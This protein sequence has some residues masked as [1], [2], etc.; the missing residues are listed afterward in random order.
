[1]G[2][3]WVEPHPYPLQ[4]LCVNSFWKRDCTEEK[5]KGLWSWQS[6]SK[7]ELLE[8]TLVWSKM[9]LTYRMRVER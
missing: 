9:T 8:S 3:M 7:L 1:M 4:E 6:D 5:L 2:R